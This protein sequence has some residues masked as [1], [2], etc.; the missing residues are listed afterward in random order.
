M[1]DDQETV[2]KTMEMGNNDVVS[3]TVIDKCNIKHTVRQFYPK[4]V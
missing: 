2:T 4:P 1:Y 3:N